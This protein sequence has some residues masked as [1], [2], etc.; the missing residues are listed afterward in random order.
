MWKIARRE[1]FTL[2]LSRYTLYST[3]SRFIA[4]SRSPF[5][6]HASI[7][8]SR[9]MG[10]R[11]T[12]KGKWKRARGMGSAKGQREWVLT[13]RMICMTSSEAEARSFVALASTKYFVLA[14][15]LLK[16][17][18]SCVTTHVFEMLT[19]ESVTSFTTTIEHNAQLTAAVATVSHVAHSF[20]VLHKHK[21]HLFGVDDICHSRK[22]GKLILCAMN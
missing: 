6:V 13:A 17:S 5:S 3:N 20:A 18:S 4:R 15:T 10:Y 9:K 22:I 2:G 12:A 7:R 16:T 14:S 8:E 21:K 1:A 11:W 19:R